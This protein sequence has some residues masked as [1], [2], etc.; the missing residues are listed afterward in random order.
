MVLSYHCYSFGLDLK[1]KQQTPVLVLQHTEILQRQTSTAGS[2]EQC[3]SG[4][5]FRVSVF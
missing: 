3:L 1:P 5:C 2:K 4:R